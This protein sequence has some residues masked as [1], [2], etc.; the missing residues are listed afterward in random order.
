MSP[1]AFPPGFV[2]IEPEEGELS[3]VALDHYLAMCAGC[4]ELGLE[5]VVTFHHFTTPRW[6]AAVGGWA[7]PATA[8]RFAR[9]CARAAGHLGDARC[10]PTPTPGPERPSRRPST[11][12]WG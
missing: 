6:A 2:R 10:S 4:R 7:E 1:R 8:E 3:R 11:C 5:P 9:F 12:R